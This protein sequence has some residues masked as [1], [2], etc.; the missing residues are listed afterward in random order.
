[1]LNVNFQ[2]FD[3]KKINGVNLLIG[4]Y[5]DEVEN[6]VQATYSCY[7]L[8]PI[9]RGIFSHFKMLISISGT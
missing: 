4:I 2:S 6:Y 9:N 5:D 7:N 3:K 8:F 1:M